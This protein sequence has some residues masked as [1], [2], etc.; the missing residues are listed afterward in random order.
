MAALLN[1]S[2]RQ[3]KIWFQN[4]RMK[5]KKD[6]KLK[7]VID[8]SPG[9]PRNGKNSDSADT[10]SPDGASGS[11]HL[12][13]GNGGMT[14]QQQSSHVTPQ[15]QQLSSPTSALAP[16]HNTQTHQ[17]LHAQQQQQQPQGPGQTPPHMSHHNMNM[18]QNLGMTNN[19]PVSAAM[20]A[21]M[22]SVGGMDTSAGL[23][24]MGCGA[25]GSQADSPMTSS[26]QSLQSLS[27][28]NMERGMASQSNH[29]PMTSQNRSPM[30]PSAAS[31]LTPPYS[32]VVNCNPNAAPPIGHP[33]TP[34]SENGSYHSYSQGNYNNAPKLTHL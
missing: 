12:V 19:S 28:M 9:D 7:G 30:G 5:H 25:P 11:E 15:Q 1:L 3:I 8:T 22:N 6:Q 16:K 32:G 23:V 24:G 34:V 31:P 2:E 20:E 27:G 10:M 33:S 18:G 29:H 26:L 14:S 21:R 13:M 4:R 17:P